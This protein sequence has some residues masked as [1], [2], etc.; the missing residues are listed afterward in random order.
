MPR[1]HHESSRDFSQ[2][3]E[4]KTNQLDRKQMRRSARKRRHYKKEYSRQNRTTIEQCQSILTKDK[5]SK[6]I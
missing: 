2:F 6:E 1:K 5:E 3:I 4:K